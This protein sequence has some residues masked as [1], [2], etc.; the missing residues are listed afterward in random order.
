MTIDDYEH[1]AVK[2]L[3]D[4][5]FGSENFLATAV[6]RNNPSGRSTV[7]GFSVNHEFAIFHGVNSENSSVGRLEHSDEQKERYDLI[8]EVGPYE[9]ENFRKSSAGSDRAS[10]PKQFY[11]IYANKETLTLRIPEL[12]WVDEIN[13]YEVLDQ[14]E[15]TELSVYP[16]DSSG[17]EKVWRWGLERA[18][19]DS[20]TLLAKWTKDDTR[21]EVYGR[22]Y[23]NQEGLLPRT[24]W[25]KPDYSAR[26]NG[27]R[28]LRDMFESNVPFDFPKALN[29]VID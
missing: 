6:I 2:Q 23:L 12:N 7:K 11:P 13:D 20:S 4:I 19:R 22:K 14:P 24:W 17:T 18:R 8:D 9:W 5:E 3:L 15:S 26:D 27:T 10:R 16:V 28:L 1:S 25:D 21:L 29:A